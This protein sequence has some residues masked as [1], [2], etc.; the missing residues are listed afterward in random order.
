[1]AGYLLWVNIKLREVKKSRCVSCAGKELT[2]HSRSSEGGR[3]SKQMN[4]CESEQ[5]AAVVEMQEG[6]REVGGA[7]KMP[8]QV[9][10]R[11]LSLEG[12]WLA[13]TALREQSTFDGYAAQPWV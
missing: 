7:M 3:A 10:G 12:L 9:C 6:E 2:T 1:M 4:G 13:G 11:L 8:G 5:H